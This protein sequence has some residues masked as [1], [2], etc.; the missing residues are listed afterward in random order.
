MSDIMD[1]IIEKLN[2]AS[3]EEAAISFALQIQTRGYG[4]YVLEPGDG[5]RYPIIIL[6]AGRVIVHSDGVEEIAHTYSVTLTWGNT[7]PWGGHSMDWDYCAEKWGN[8]NRWT[9]VVMA[10]LLTY[11]ARELNR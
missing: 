5:T 10:R 8:D 1:R 9:G 6:P 3:I 7:Y 2:D 11:L 4:E